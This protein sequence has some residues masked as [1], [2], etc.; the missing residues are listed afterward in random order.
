VT[1][2]AS[3]PSSVTRLALCERDHTPGAVDGAWWPKSLDLSSEL[4]DLIAVLG[5]WIGEVHRVVYDP[6]VWLRAPARVIRRNEMVS[7][8]PYRLIFSDTVYLMG[9]H[10]RDAVLFVLSPSSPGEE[11]RRLM[12]EVSGSARPMNAGALRQLVRQYASG[13]G[14]WEDLAPSR[15]FPPRVT[16]DESMISSIPITT[17][18]SP[19]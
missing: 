17:P 11:V 19:L 7:L 10:S 18:S 13:L 4:P 8:D 14:R 1:H 16:R 2:V 12:C 5:S 3:N 9:T 6:S 15:E